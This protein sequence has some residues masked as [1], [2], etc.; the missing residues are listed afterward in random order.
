MLIHGVVI[1]N[2]HCH[3]TRC[4]W[5]WLYQPGHH[6]SPPSATNVVVNRVSLTKSGNKSNNYETPRWQI[7]NRLYLSCNPLPPRSRSPPPPNPPRSSPEPVSIYHQCEIK[8]Q[9]SST[10]AKISV[11]YLDPRTPFPRRDLFQD[12]ALIQEKSISQMPAQ[13][14]IAGMLK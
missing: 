7:C 13:G 10:C 5:R 14:S 12:H 4:R 6:R 9:I 3:W 1:A 11:P 8:G 2:C